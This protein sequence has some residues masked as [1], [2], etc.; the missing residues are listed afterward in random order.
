MTGD[1]NRRDALN[2][3]TLQ[4]KSLSCTN[5]VIYNVNRKPGII[6]HPEMAKRCYTLKEA[7]NLISLLLTIHD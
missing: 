1:G 5:D 3:K 4:M 2:N 6:Y 7:T